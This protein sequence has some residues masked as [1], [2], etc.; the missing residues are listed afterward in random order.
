MSYNVNRNVSFLPLFLFSFP[1]CLTCS[2]NWCFY[3][4]YKD[5][6]FII[7]IPKTLTILLLINSIVVIF[8]ITERYVFHV[9][10]CYRTG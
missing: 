5:N 10:G 9:P 1:Y 4:A 6:A 8:F 3:F 7:D 2:L